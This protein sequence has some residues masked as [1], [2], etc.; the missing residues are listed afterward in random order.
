MSAASSSVHIT[1]RPEQTFQRWE[2]FGSSILSWHEPHPE[3]P[4][5]KNVPAE[6][7]EEAMRLAYGELGLTRARFFPRP[8]QPE[9]ESDPDRP[10]DWRTLLQLE[11]GDCDG[12]VATVQA[13][14]RHGLRDWYPC[15]QVDGRVPGGPPPWMRPANNHRSLAPETYDDYLDLLMLLTRHWRDRFGL[16]PSFWSLCNEPTYPPSRPLQI[17]IDGMLYLVKALGRRLR[18]DGF[19]TRIVMPDDWTPQYTTVAYAEAVL[20][21]PEAR[22]YVAGVGFHGYDSYEKPFLDWRVLDL[23]REWRRRLR[24]VCRYYNV[25]AWQTE[26]CSIQP[27]RDPFDD[28]LFRANH[29]HD[30][31]TCADAATWDYMWGIWQAEWRVE[32]GWGVQSPVYVRFDE[33][34][35]PSDVFCNELA[36]ILGQWSKAV[37][38]GAVRV[39]ARSDDPEVRV[40]AFRQGEET[41]LVAINNRAEPVMTNLRLDDLPATRAVAGFA[42]AEGRPWQPLPPHRMDDGRDEATLVGRSITTLTFKPAAPLHLS[43]PRPVEIALDP[44][45]THQEIVGFGGSVLNWPESNW[46]APRLEHLPAEVEEEAMRLAHRELGLTVARIFP[47]VFP[48]DAGPVDFDHPACAGLAETIRRSQ[49]HGLKTWFGTVEIGPVARTVNEPITTAWLEANGRALRADRYAAYADH[50]VA[51]LRHWRDDLGLPLTA[52]GLC[53]SPSTPLTKPQVITPDGARELTKVVGRKLQNAGLETRLLAAGDAIVAEYGIDFTRTVLA[54]DEARAYVLAAEFQ[55]RDGYSSAYNDWRYLNGQRHS[56]AEFAAVCRPYGVPT[57]QTES[58]T[59]NPAATHLADALFRANNIHDDLTFGG[60]SVWLHRSLVWEGGWRENLGYESRGPAAPV[61]IYFDEQSRPD[62]VVIAKLGHV[63]GQWSR[64]VRSGARQIDATSS[65]ESVRVTAFTGPEPGK[66]V[67]V[68]INNHT[69]AVDAAVSF[70]GGRPP[71]RLE[72]WRT[73]DREDGASAAAPTTADGALRLTL[74]GESVTTLVA[75]GYG[76]WANVPDQHASA[77]SR[78]APDRGAPVSEWT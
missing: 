61:L 6:A 66:T 68:V 56:R 18:A 21:D 34:G 69:H 51:F 45:V 42:T 67:L 46:E 29:I 53:R 47:R 52:W 16:E 3:V 14:Q 48:T 62:R 28:A 13:L 20:A 63:M 24:D 31:L 22:S 43:A 38:P 4:L 41:T 12:Y 36:H 73:S 9:H 55:G 1:I 78:S 2:G 71:S 26:S 5:F 77:I 60:A 30:D 76:A 65:D 54:D 10:E 32:K 58:L 49:A 11:A 25:P 44:S 57:W 19:A 27:G 15:F 74:L 64:W 70:T 17:P 7:L 59:L 8:F 37:R 40:T 33:Q 75:H 23:Q 35:H 39:E 72:C 50:L